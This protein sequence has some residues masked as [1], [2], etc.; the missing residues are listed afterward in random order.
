MQLGPAG[1]DG[2]GATEAI[3]S[4]CSRC[5]VVIH[6]MHDDD[7]NRSEARTAGASEFVS[8]QQGEGALVSA[9]R[10]AASG[11]AVHPAS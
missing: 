11:L 3:T 7:A 6:T 5:A 9:I 2:I 4:G 1:I 8:K 10:R